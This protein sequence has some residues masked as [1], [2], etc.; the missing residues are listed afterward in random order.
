MISTQ[1]TLTPVSS[2]NVSPRPDAPRGLIQYLESLMILIS[3]PQLPANEHEL[4]HP[5]PCNFSPLISA[6]TLPTN[7]V[8]TQ[9][10]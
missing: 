9:T 2:I 6:S 4:Y 7:S 5:E 3:N 1:C 8:I 10:W